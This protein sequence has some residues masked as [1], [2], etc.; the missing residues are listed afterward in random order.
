MPLVKKPIRVGDSTGVVLDPEILR[1]VV[2][3]RPENA[4]PTTRPALKRPA[5]LKA[6]VPG[7]AVDSVP[8]SGTK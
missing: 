6:W 4:G 5:N 1:H 7:G 2:E 8:A 3:I